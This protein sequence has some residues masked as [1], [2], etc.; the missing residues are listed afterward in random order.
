MVFVTVASIVAAYQATPP[1]ASAGQAVPAAAATGGLRADATPPSAATYV[2]TH[3]CVACHGKE[4]DAWRGSDHDL[5]MQPATPRTALGNFADAKLAADGVVSTF[6]KSGDTPVVRT[7]G[8]D[9]ALADFPLKYTFGVRPL[10]QYLIDVGGGRLQALGIA[11]D[12]RPKGQGGQRWF[13]LYPQQKLKP[14]NPLHW[15]GIDQNWNYQCAD[16]HST[17]VRKGYDERTGTFDTKWSD[18]NVGCEA[19][20]GP[21]W[22]HLAWTGKDADGQRLDPDKGFAV[23]FDERAGAAWTIDAATGNAVRARPRSTRREI[24]TCGRCHARRGQ[25]TDDWRPGQPLGDA[26]RVALLE[27]GLYYP[28]GQQRDEVYTYGSFLQSLMYAKGVTCSDC[29][30]PHSTKLRATGNA[31]CAQCHA[32]A[33]YDVETHT[34]HPAGS[35]GAQCVSC[36]MPPRTYMVV[37][38]RHDHSFRIPR[39]DRAITLGVPSPC[40]GC[41]DTQ[42]AQ[43]AVDTLAKWFPNRR[44]GFQ[45]FAEGLHAGD[46]GAPGAQAMLA[47]IATD[48]AQ[49]PV[50]RASAVQRLGRFLSPR[51]ITSIGEALG[52]TEPLVRAA[53]IGAVAQIP[54]PMRVQLLPRLLDDPIRQVRMEAAHALAGEAEASLAA[55]AHPAFDRA[56]AEWVASERF[57]ADRPEAQSALADLAARRGHADEAAATYRK[58]LTLDPTFEAAALNLA[59]LQRAQDHDGDAER[60]IR[61]A[62]K[63]A[64]QSAPAHYALGLTLVRQKRLP[65]AVTELREASRLAPDDARLA[66]TYAVALHDTGKAPEALEMLRT[67]LRRSPYDRPLLFALVTY[68]RESGDLTQARAHAHL[69]QELEPDDPN[70]ARLAATL[71]SGAP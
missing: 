53:A 67:A 4:A 60:T 19:C 23:R 3:A 66:H 24:D 44:A 69:L 64:P 43:W 33:K 52:D 42:S 71:E 25:F 62:L 49:S 9:G 27:P 70:L 11:W 46:V 50:V 30:E 29:H 45:T 68:E 40:H 36:H 32:T 65:E 54:A 20:H 31:V 26:F 63:R 51:T 16:C 57:N 12:A 14:G 8:P 55:S 58:A 5:A 1:P 28:D 56:L 34:H 22:S 7:D 59:D 17:A 47:R 41:H 13:R 21:A 10:Q 2:G 61:D 37:D 38:P 39:P 15:T 48:G 18:L 35:T 6:K